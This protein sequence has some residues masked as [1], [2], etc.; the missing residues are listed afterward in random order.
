MKRDSAKQKAK[1]A[2]ATV[3]AAVSGQTDIAVCGPGSGQKKAYA[4]SLHVEIWDEDMF[5][6]AISKKGGP[7]KRKAAEPAKGAAKS[8]KKKE[9]VE[10]DDE[11]EDLS[12][13]AL[14]RVG[15]FFFFFF[16]F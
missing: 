7:K 4:E 10:E 11:E 9:E 8:K 2:G 12:E 15:F 5:V 16:F 14:K 13:G 6:E 3:Q 1:D